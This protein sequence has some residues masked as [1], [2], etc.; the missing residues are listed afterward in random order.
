MIETMRETIETQARTIRYLLTNY[1]ML[2]DKVEGE[3]EAEAHKIANYTLTEQQTTRTW[4]DGK[5]IFQTTVQLT[6]AGVVNPYGVNCSSWA[7]GITTIDNV[8]DMEFAWNRTMAF[9]NGTSNDLQWCGVGPTTT[10]QDRWGQQRDQFSWT[11]DP[12]YINI[13]NVPA[14]YW[15]NS[16]FGPPLSGQ[17]A[18]TPMIFVTLFYTK[19]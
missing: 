10:G 7:H 9:W 6:Q 11:V 4:V 17:P 18:K 2:L 5:P 3:E 1:Q 12:L 15:D 19:Q 14:G 13:L 16:T 8:I